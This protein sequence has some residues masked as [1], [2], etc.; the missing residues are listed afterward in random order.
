MKKREQTEADIR[1]ELQLRCNRSTQRKVA[2]ELGYSFQFINDVLMGR[3][4]ITSELAAQL[5]YERVTV[6]RK[7]TQAICAKPVS[8]NYF[9]GLA[10]N[11]RGKCG[12]RQEPHP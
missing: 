2:K 11:H 7:K 9:C 5:G 6:F 1:A 12:Q 3:R 10:P 4:G 8:P